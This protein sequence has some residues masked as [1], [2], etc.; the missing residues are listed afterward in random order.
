MPL[1]RR[2][3]LLAPGSGT[4]TRH[5]EPDTARLHTAVNAVYASVYAVTETAAL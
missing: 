1:G 3:E 2:T 5:A 4:R